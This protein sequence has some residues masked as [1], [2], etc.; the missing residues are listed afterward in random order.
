MPLQLL[1]LLVFVPGGLAFALAY[2][3]RRRPELLASVLLFVVFYV[4]YG[5]GATETAQW[6]RRVVLGLRFFLPLLP[7]LAFATGESAPR[8]LE[9]LRAARP[10]RR[11]AL[12]LAASIV[13]A[14]WIAGVGGAALGVHAVH[15]RF[16]AAQATLRD[17]IRDHAGR[18]A[19]L[20]T[21]KSATGKF[22]PWLSTRFLPLDR[23][24]LAPREARRMAD[25]HDRVLLILLDRADSAF[26]RREAQ[27]NAAFADGL[28]EGAVAE[29]DRSL[30]T[31]E[32]L[33]IWRV[34]GRGPAG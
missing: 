5:Y 30:P 9:R 18:D 10:A 24:E 13:L 34:R 11:D 12:A 17:A 31:G 32:R 4:V 6:S 28:G 14:V 20:V 23:S 33:R 16:T 26:W 15:H 7:V 1:G 8:L 22:V 29:L 2:R 25:R 19:V 3:G 21:N 27:A